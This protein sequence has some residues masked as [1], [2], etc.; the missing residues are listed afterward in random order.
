M[1]LLSSTSDAHKKMCIIRC[2]HPDCLV[3]ARSDK[4]SD[5]IIMTSSVVQML[6]CAS[7]VESRVR[8]TYVDF[9]EE[10]SWSL[11]AYDLRTTDRADVYVCIA[12][13]KHERLTMTAIIG[14]SRAGHTIQSITANSCMRASYIYCPSLIISY[15]PNEWYILFCRK[16]LWAKRTW[17]H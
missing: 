10:Q 15:N 9:L 12:G 16:E 8:R 2:S 5:S 6:W 1:N 11:R 4:V 13:D 7:V 14:R 17:W 3:E